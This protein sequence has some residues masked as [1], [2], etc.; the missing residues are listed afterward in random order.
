M[1][2]CM[3]AGDAAD[4][5]FSLVQ[6]L[7]QLGL[8]I[9]LLGGDDYENPKYS[10]QVMFINIRGSRDA[11]A[12]WRDKA[13]RVLRYYGRL[14]RH[15]WRS[16]AKAVHMQAFRFPFIEGVLLVLLIKRLGK[17]VV[18]TAHNVQPKGRD[19]PLNRIVFRLIYMNVDRIICHSNDMKHKLMSRYRVAAD[20]I[21]IAGHGLFDQ[22]PMQVIAQ[23]E[24]RRR[25]DLDPE[26][27][28]VL[29]FGRIRP[30]KGY[31]LAFEALEYVS[32]TTQPVLYLIAGQAMK[33]QN[34]KYLGHLK[35]LVNEQKLGDMVRFDDFHIPESDLELY[36]QAA[37]VALLPYTEGDFQSGVLFLAYRFGLP[38]IVSDVGSFPDDVVPGVQG[39]VF[40]AGNPQSL[41]SKLD[42][43]YQCL[44]PQ[45]DLRQSIRAY[46]EKQYSW[47]Q[48]AATTYKLYQQVLR[49][50]G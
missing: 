31:E 34:H 23:E 32:E 14:I 45:P 30:Y 27:K 3:V 5:V 6:A 21:T 48:A 2:V 29:L 42:T 10:P 7:A 9:E 8:R 39:Y 12:A 38:V 1:K 24:A 33:A 13:T 17:C 37:D 16:E 20:K 28:V 18:Y 50:Q 44:H 15:I 46:T 40:E 47:E 4:Y 22:V 41:A 26:V 19:T 25:L 11:R 49:D 35:A 36:F 43:F